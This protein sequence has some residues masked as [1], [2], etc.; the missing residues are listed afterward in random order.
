[1]WAWSGFL[2]SIGLCLTAFA[3]SLYVALRFLLLVISME[4]GILREFKNSSKAVDRAL[5]DIPEKEAKLKSFIQS[6]M[7]PTDGE[8][9]PQSDEEAFINE[10]VDHLRRQGMTDDELDAFIRQAA[11]TDIGK[12][13]TNG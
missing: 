3:A 9:V 12:T 4:A 8:F 1:M 10:Q 6:R 11:G 13:E 5:S 7:A 2:F